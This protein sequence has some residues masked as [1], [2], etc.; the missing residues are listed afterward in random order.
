MPIHSIKTFSKQKLEHKIHCK[1]DLCKCHCV[2]GLDCNPPIQTNFKKSWIHTSNPRT[3]F[4]FE[5]IALHLCCVV[6]F[7]WLASNTSLMGANYTYQ[8]RRHCLEWIEAGKL[9][10]CNKKEFGFVNDSKCPRV[11]CLSLHTRR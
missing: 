11:F 3:Q 1:K 6:L 2:V 9:S 7:I 4:P 5:E 8:E 10:G